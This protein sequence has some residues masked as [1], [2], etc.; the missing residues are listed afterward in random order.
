MPKA[1]YFFE[2]LF[3]AFAKRRCDDIL[4][5]GERFEPQGRRSSAIEGNWP[6]IERNGMKK[7]YVE[8]NLF[9][10]IFLIL[11]LLAF[12]YTQ[13]WVVRSGAPGNDYAYYIGASNSIR[14]GHSPYYEGW[15]YIYP[16]PLAVVLLPLS[17][18]DH[19]TG[20]GIWTIIGI[21]AYGFAACRSGHCGRYF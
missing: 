5:E 8:T 4:I 17:F 10:A 19:R 11:L 15:W 13:T 20:Y 7:K 2:L 14:H 16:P 3:N 1:L 18:F 9:L 12:A 21:A 6:S